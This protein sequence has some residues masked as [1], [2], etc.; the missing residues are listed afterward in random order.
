[1]EEYTKIAFPATAVE[2]EK[3]RYRFYDVELCIARTLR[4]ADLFDRV[5]LYVLITES[6]CRNPWLETAKAAVAG[7]ADAL[8]LREKE[9]ESGELL[10]RARILVE[11]CRKHDVLLIVND[12]P[13]IA[14]LSGADGVHVGQGDLPAVEAR[15]VVGS[16][17]IVGVSTHHIDQ[18]ARQRWTVRTISVSA[19]SF[20]AAQS[21]AMGRKFPGWTTPGRLPPVC[22][23]PPLRSRESPSR[24]LSG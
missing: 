5:R 13:D 4:P 20:E 15:K 22:A 1:M 9:M 2:L 19:R 11:L 14:M 17:R 6:A 23:S 21:R 24:M 7:G 8:Q 3:L 18:G 12:R 10:R 16:D